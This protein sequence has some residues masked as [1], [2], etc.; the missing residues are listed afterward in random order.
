MMAKPDSKLEGFWF[1]SYLRCIMIKIEHGLIQY[2][3]AGR[4]E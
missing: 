2:T 3:G 4:K 1:R